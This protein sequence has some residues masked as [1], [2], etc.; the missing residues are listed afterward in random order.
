MLQMTHRLGLRYRLEDDFRRPIRV[1]EIQGGG[2]MKPGLII[3]TKGEKWV[4]KPF[5][6]AALGQPSKSGGEAAKQ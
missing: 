1:E 5:L 6:I 4:Q 3:R 2:R